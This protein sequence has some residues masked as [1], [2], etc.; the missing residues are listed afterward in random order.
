MALTAVAAGLARHARVDR[1][2]RAGGEIRHLGAD[3]LDHAGDLV[4]ERHR[5]LDPHGAEAA[6]VVVV[7]VR[8]ADAARRD[9]DADLVRSRRHDGDVLDPQV[10]G[11][12]D[13]DAAHGEPPLLS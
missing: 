1:D 10:L 11:R 13:D 12:V 4:P 7:Q 6:V 5:L 2:A 9:A 3:L 8:A